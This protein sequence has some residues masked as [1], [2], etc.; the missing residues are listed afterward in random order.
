MTRGTD[1]LTPN[2][3]RLAEEKEDPERKIIEQVLDGR[4]ASGPARAAAPRKRERRPSKKASTGGARPYL[5]SAV[6]G[7]LATAWHDDGEDKAPKKLVERVCHAL[8][9]YFRPELLERRYRIA[10]RIRKYEKPTAGSE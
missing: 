6:V 1:T 3:D 5:L 2:V 4:Q 7:E 9:W 10:Q 8:R